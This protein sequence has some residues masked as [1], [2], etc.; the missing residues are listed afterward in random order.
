MQAD[1][2]EIMILPKSG[3]ALACFKRRARVSDPKL[4]TPFS[5][6]SRT[7]E[8]LIKRKYAGL[9]IGDVCKCMHS[10]LMHL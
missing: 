5:A 9:D 6:A 7:L 8:I 10:L 2:E 4:G 1:A 3:L